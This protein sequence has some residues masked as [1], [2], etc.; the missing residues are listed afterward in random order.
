M[1][2]GNGH[3]HRI[4]PT[5]SWSIPLE[6]YIFMRHC[7][8]ELLF[9]FFF[10]AE[11]FVKYIFSA[12]F[13]FDR[14]KFTEMARN[15][16]FAFTFVFWGHG[17]G[18]GEDQMKSNWFLSLTLCEQFVAVSVVLREVSNF[19]ETKRNI[20]LA[21]VALSIRRWLS[22]FPNIYFYVFDVYDYNITSKFLKTNFCTTVTYPLWVHPLTHTHSHTNTLPFLRKWIP[23]QDKLP[24][25]LAKFEFVSLITELDL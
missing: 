20:I 17:E 8:N 5:Y 13:F 21:L 14:K 22:S 3:R 6:T 18:V 25:L 11:K 16:S 24:G 15:E 10:H 19:F 7:F 12:V 23:N 4:S 9:D 1:D 2:T